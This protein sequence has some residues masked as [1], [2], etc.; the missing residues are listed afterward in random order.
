MNARWENLDK[1]NTLIMKMKLKNK[2]KSSM[3]DLNWILYT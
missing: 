2:V 1:R 3:I